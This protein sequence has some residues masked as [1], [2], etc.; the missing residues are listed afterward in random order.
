M[1]KKTSKQVEGYVYALLQSSDLA[2]SLSGGVYR[3]G[4]RPRDSKL[5]DAV[6][7]FTSGRAAEQIQT[8][9]VTLNIYVPDIDPYAN[10]V[11]VEDGSRVEELQ[12]LAQAWADS[13]TCSV[14]DGYRFRLAQT[15][16]SEEEADLGQHFVVVAL[17]YEYYDGEE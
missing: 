8:G 15:I 10:G 14:T 7:I 1:A 9:V 13:L 17:D 11:L 4:L 6:V 5:E 3:Q 2:S 12:S 16:T